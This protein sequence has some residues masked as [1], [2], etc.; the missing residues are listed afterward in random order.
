MTGVSITWL[1]VTTI[2]L[3]SLAVCAPSG[4][5]NAINS[6]ISKELYW[7]GAYLSLTSALLSILLWIWQIPL[8]AV[9]GVAFESFFNEILP[10]FISTI[11]GAF[12][13]I[14]L[15]LAIQEKSKIGFTLLSLGY[16]LLMTGLNYM[17]FLQATVYEFCPLA[18]SRDEAV[19]IVAS[20]FLSATIAVLS[21]L[22]K[23]YRNR[24]TSGSSPLASF[25]RDGRKPAP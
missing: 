16:C 22:Y 23:K 15:S 25:T 1:L 19:D 5:K 18:G 12:L 24:L 20:I 9:F 13:W 17:P 4:T 14:L 21:Y 11:F 8:G 7:A 10:T 2:A 3:F 6:A